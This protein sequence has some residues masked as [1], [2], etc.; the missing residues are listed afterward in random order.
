MSNKKQTSIDWF[1]S[2]LK[3]IL[4]CDEVIH[5]A[6]A[7]AMFRQQIED[8]VKSGENNVDEFGEYIISDYPK[9]YFEQ[10]FKN[11]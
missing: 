5:H 9:K 2:C 11:D 8:A 3:G 10:T 7:K 1:A 6:K 4:N